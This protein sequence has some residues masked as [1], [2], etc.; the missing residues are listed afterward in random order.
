MQLCKEAVANNGAKLV[1][2]HLAMIWKIDSISDFPKCP[3]DLFVWEYET[4]S[5][6]EHDNK[7]YFC[8]KLNNRQ[9]LT[10][11]EKFLTFL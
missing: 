6:D 8:Q 5:Q 7:E 3:R 4:A 2:V 1:E 9:L 10:E 11:S